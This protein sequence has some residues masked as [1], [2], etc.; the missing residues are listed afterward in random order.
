MAKDI[1]DKDKLEIAVD[2]LYISPQHFNSIE[3]T[4]AE[5]EIRDRLEGFKVWAKKLISEKV[6]D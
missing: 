5:I 1:K 6:K 3:A 2:M 4:K